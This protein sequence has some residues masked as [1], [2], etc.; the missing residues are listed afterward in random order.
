MVQ[1]NQIGLEK[2]TEVNKGETVSFSDDC[3]FSSQEEY[4]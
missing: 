1:E 3:E 4:E 2:M